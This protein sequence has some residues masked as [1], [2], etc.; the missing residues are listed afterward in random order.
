MV[1]CQHCNKSFD[2]DFEFCP[3][4]GTPKPAPNFCPQCTIDIPSDFRYCPKCGTKLM[5]RPEYFKEKEEVLLLIVH[6]NF[7]EAL[8]KCHYLLHEKKFNKEV[9]SEITEFLLEEKIKNQE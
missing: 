4:C 9:I 1:L 7:E 5:S 6:K 3:Y 2:D 8:V